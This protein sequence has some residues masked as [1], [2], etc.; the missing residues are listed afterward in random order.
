[1]PTP[2]DSGW[3]ICAPPRPVRKWRPAARSPRSRERLC[4][5]WH[6]PICSLAPAPGCDARGNPGARGHARHHRPPACGGRPNPDSRRAATSRRAGALAWLPG[7]WA[8]PEAPARRLGYLAG[9]PSGWRQLERSRPPTEGTYRHSRLS[10]R[11]AVPHDPSGLRSQARARAYRPERISRLGQSHPNSV[12]GCRPI[13]GRI[14]SFSSA[15]H[16]VTPRC[17]EVKRR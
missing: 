1:M 12:T 15:W 17:R 7:H 8:R 6:T 16:G 4:C 13:T 14:H 3:V 9:P 10:V 5:S 2:N 11:P